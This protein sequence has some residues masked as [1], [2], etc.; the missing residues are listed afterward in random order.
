[1]CCVSSDSPERRPPGNE[2]SSSRDHQALKEADP[3]FPPGS[4][5]VITGIMGAGKSTVAQRLAESLP[6]AVHV[7]GD[8]FRRT[9]VS[10][11]AEMV[12]GAGD[13]ALSQLR[14]RYAL[15][16]Q[17]V[18]GYASAG[19]TAVYQDIILG[20][21][22]AATA[23]RIRSRPLFIVVLAPRAEVAL[24]RA[25]ARSKASGYGE[26]TAQGLD[27]LLRSSQRLGLWLDTSDQT[28]EQTADEIR[29]RA[30][31]ARLRDARLAPGS[32]ANVLLVKHDGDLISYDASVLWDDGNHLVVRATWIEDQPRDLGFAI[33]APGDVFTEHYWRDRWYSIKEVRDRDGVLKG[34]YCDVAHPAQ[35]QAGVIV[36]ADLI[37]DLWVPATGN[38]LRLDEDEFAAS[39]VVRAESLAT[40]ARSALVELERLAADQFV[41]ESVAVAAE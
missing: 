40:R 16:A 5:V 18:D 29:A 41:G 15:A 27:Q 26:W 13:D 39:A 12:P 33:F 8:L 7:R 11:R 20:D 4:V 36:S 25:A 21:D 9:I 14:L 34:W 35:V 6:R 31:E 32:R 17:A 37:L 22:L 30:E 2:G 10:G 28:A 19:F 23:H 38:P 24:A 1:M 3:A